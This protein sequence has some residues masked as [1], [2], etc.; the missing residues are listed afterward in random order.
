MAGAPDSVASSM[1]RRK[2]SEKCRPS[3]VPLIVELYEATLVLADSM[4]TNFFRAWSPQTTHVRAL[5]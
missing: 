1:Q 4:R 3:S 2:V 5:A